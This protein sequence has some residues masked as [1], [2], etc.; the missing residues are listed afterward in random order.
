MKYAGVVIFVVFIY[1]ALSN[2]IAV[3]GGQ[4]I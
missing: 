2:Y 3:N 4:N 1:G